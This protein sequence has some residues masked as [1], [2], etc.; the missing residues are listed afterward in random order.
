MAKKLPATRWNIPY[1]TATEFGQRVV[2]RFVT[3]AGMDRRKVRR[4]LRRVFLQLGECNAER[5]IREM[6]FSR[7]V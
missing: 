5:A 2:W 7:Y 3:P 1:D 4:I 6:G